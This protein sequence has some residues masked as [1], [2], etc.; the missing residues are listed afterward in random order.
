M[1]TINLPLAPVLSQ[2]IPDHAILPYFLKV[3]FSIIPFKAR[4]PKWSLSFKFPYRNPLCIFFPSS[5]VKCPSHHTVF[6][7]I[8]RIILMNAN[9]EVPL[10]VIFDSPF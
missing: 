10:Y 7:L 1:F 8:R 4:S 2:R 6:D 3:H 5:S 9:H